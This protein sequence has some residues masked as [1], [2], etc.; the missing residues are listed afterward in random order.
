M[1]FL[2]MTGKV[3]GSGFLIV[4]II[5]LS[6][7]LFA[8]NLIDGIDDI[9]V[10]IQDELEELLTE[11]KDEL[12]LT[13]MEGE[14]GPMPD[15]DKEQIRLACEQGLQEIPDE[16]CDNIDTMT[17]DEILATMFGGIL[18]EQGIFGD[19]QIQE[20]ISSIN[21]PLMEVKQKFNGLSK[22]LIV[23]IIFIIIGILIIFLSYF[24]KLWSAS[25]L[26]SLD[27]AIATLITTLFSGITYGLGLD[28]LRKMIEEILVMNQ[29][30]VPALFVNFI[31]EVLSVWVKTAVSSVFY[32]SLI[33]FILAVIASVVFY[34]KK[35]KG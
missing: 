30:S 35:F 10:I 4:G 24:F 12:L 26:V 13:A 32:L 2:T 3:I 14:I 22:L 11:N 34:I 17:E 29:Q 9:S 5:I 20:A 18:E 19:E 15:I 7:L 6:L 31:A 1:G 33:V 21:E 28:S 27:I 25:F 8:N 23:P 16:I